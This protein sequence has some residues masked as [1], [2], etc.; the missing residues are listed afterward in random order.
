MVKV[1]HSLGSSILIFY[2]IEIITRVEISS[3]KGDKKILCSKL[4]LSQ[5]SLTSTLKLNTKKN[6]LMNIY[7]LYF[8]EITRRWWN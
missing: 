5:N 7:T 2:N 8:F 6:I 1:I 3:K 4:F